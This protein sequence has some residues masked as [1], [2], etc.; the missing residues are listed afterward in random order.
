MMNTSKQGK[1]FVQ[2]HQL[3][4]RASPPAFLFGLPIINIPFVLRA[5]PHKDKLPRLRAF[6]LICFCVHLVSHDLSA[7]SHHRR[8][9]EQCTYIEKSEAFDHER[10]PEDAV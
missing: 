3:K 5:S 8:R 2:L 9:K 1:L 4:G 6:S 10:S 7:K